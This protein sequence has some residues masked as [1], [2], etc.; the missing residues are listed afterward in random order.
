MTAADLDA[1]DVGRDQ[2]AGDAEIVFLTEQVVRVAQLE[3]QPQH[4]GN[5]CQGDVALVPGQAHAEHLFPFPFS[6]A[7]DAEVRDGARIRTRFRAGQ[8]EAGDL[9]A[10]GEAGQ[11]MVFLLLGA[12][13]LQQLTRP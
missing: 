1:L 10:D 9:L 8:G 11:V 4:G 6:L 5:R 13:V 7:D 2:G 12:I 3:G